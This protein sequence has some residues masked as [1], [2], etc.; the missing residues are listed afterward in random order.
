M[1]TIFLKNI[2]GLTYAPKRNGWHKEHFVMHY[3]HVKQNL[4]HLR[5]VM[6]LSPTTKIIM[7]TQKTITRCWIGRNDWHSK[8]CTQTGLQDIQWRMKHFDIW[9][10]HYLCAASI[11]KVYLADTYILHSMVHWKIIKTWRF[12]CSVAVQTPAVRLCLV[13]AM[14]EKP[15]TIFVHDA[16]SNF[17]IYKAKQ[18]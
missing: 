14:Y 8:N 16:I 9:R 2:L 5:C 1:Q 11:G 17:V 12:S 3:A 13:R 18:F 10:G 4:E 6:P 15:F 7:K